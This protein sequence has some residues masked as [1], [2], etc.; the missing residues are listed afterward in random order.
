MKENKTIWEPGKLF[1]LVMFWKHILICKGLNLGRL[2][3]GKMYRNLQRS[4]L[5]LGHYHV[6]TS[7]PVKRW[8]GEPQ[9]P[10]WEKE[11]GTPDSTMSSRSLT[12]FNVH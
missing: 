10:L 7:S 3:K 6:K 8:L 2:F 11:N 5:V 4:Q 12:K 9:V 1:K